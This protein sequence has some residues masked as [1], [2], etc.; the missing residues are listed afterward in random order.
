MN[1]FGRKIR[2]GGIGMKKKIAACAL[3]AAMVFGGAG[4]PEGVF[5]GVFSGNSIVAD[6]AVSKDGQYRYSVTSEENKEAC[7]LRFVNPAASLTVPSVID[8]YTITSVGSSSSIV[9]NNSKSVVQSISLPEGVVEIGDAA[10]TGMTNLTSVNIPSTVRSVTANSFANT[11]IIN[12]QS[13]SM[14]YVDNWLISCDTSLTSADFK[15]G[16]IGIA[17]NAFKDCKSLQTISIPASVKYILTNA[18]STCTSLKSVTFGADPEYVGE[19]A[20][21]GC[22]SL[23]T[24]DVSKLTEIPDSLFSQCSSLTTVKT[25]SA[26]TKIGKWAFQNTGLKSFDIPSTVTSIG[27]QAFS[28]TPMLSGQGTYK[29]VGSWIVDADTTASS[30]DIPAGAVGLASIYGNSKSLTSVSFPSSLKYISDSTFEGCTSLSKV[31][32]SDG[33]TTIGDR[34]FYSCYGLSEIALPGTL[35]KIGAYA[36]AKCQ[37]NLDG[38]TTVSIPAGIG[39]IGDCA[40]LGDGLIS[41]IRIE[42][43]NV[44]MGNY[45]IG[46]STANSAAKNT[47]LTIYC[48]KDSTVYNYASSHGF[49]TELL[50]GAAQHEHS[51]TWVTTKQ[52]TCTETGTKTGT[53]SCGDTKYETVPALGHSATGVAAKAATCTAAGNTAYWHC[54]RCGKYFSD[55][56]CTKEITLASTVI[57]AKGH[58]YQATVVAPTCTEKGY[59]FH[60]CSVCGDSYKDTE[61]AALG[62][63]YKDTVVAPTATTQGYTTHT[64]ERCGNSYTDSYT[65]ATG[66]T[67]DTRKKG[68]LNNNGKIDASDLLQVKSHIKKVKLLTGNDLT[69]ADVDGNGAI[70]AADLLRMKSHMKGVTLLWK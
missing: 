14:K 17:K 12:N 29:Y 63:K 18:F 13:G 4:L 33:L 21:Y 27:Y 30:A 48:Y 28:G 2:F 5:S 6:A 53:C 69:C 44:Q 50:D 57:A 15:S 42:S 68:D 49:K 22:S 46:F 56:A 59:T 37:Q 47:G 25:S 54:S 70:N 11:G 3:A 8:D 66:Q 41:N 62:H 20:F 23:A 35:T 61:T 45:C 55:A 9:A 51:Y 52:P 16:T 38:L 32:F 64:C 67:T 1:G 24:A 60:K 58:N 19:G 31:T 36:F 65:P 26:L 34:A 10:F 7:F 39:V 40:F 43:A